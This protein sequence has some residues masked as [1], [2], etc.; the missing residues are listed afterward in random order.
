MGEFRLSIYAK[1]QLGL[2]ISYDGQI[3]LRLPFIDIRLAVSKHAKD[4][5][6]FGR[7]Y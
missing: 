1:W 4:V 3:V 5:F 2:S 6:I 7:V